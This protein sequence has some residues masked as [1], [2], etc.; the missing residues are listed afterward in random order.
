MI[1][2]M[3]LFFR[4]CTFFA[5]VTM[6]FVSADAQDL[7]NLHFKG[8][9][10]SKPKTSIV[11]RLSNGAISSPTHYAT[12]GDLIVVLP[13]DAAMRHKYPDL[14]RAR[15][16]FPQKRETEELRNV[17]VDCWIHAVKFEDGRGGNPGD[18]DFHVIIGSSADTSQATYMTTEVT[19]LP[20]SGKNLP[21]LKGARERFLKIIQGTSPTTAFKRVSPAIKVRLSGSL[22]F[23]GDHRAGCKSCPGPA[24]AKPETVWEIH[25]VYAIEEIQ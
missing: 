9:Y 23:D 17:E 2:R 13:N 16:G 3:R 1:R 5:A 10:R 7:L 24:W 14:N 19:G 11:R 6:L 22:F 4:L 21:V 8:H 25:P 15:S 20:A 18:N 12:I